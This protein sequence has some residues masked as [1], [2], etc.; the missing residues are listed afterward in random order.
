MLVIVLLV[1][2]ALVLGVFALFTILAA[3]RD[4]VERIKRFAVEQYWKFVKGVKWVAS[5]KLEYWPILLCGACLVI[6]A[7]TILCPTGILH[8]VWGN[9]G[10]LKLII[11]LM[12]DMVDIFINVIRQQHWLVKFLIKLIE[13]AVQLCMLVIVITVRIATDPNI[14]LIVLWAIALPAFASVVIWNIESSLSNRWRAMLM[15]DRDGGERPIE[16]MKNKL[17]IMC[18]ATIVAVMIA[19]T[20]V[21]KVPKFKSL[22]LGTTDVVILAVVVCIAQVFTT[23][24][25]CIQLDGDT[26]PGIS[27]G[28]RMIFWND[29]TVY[30]HYHFTLFVTCTSITMLLILAPFVNTALF[31]HRRLARI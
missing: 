12:S 14:P 20:I 4:D 1:C 5:Q 22:L 6:R 10:H 31:T 8:T 19:I 15:T 28:K 9:W 29:E 26:V 24:M 3:T 27:N 7:C 13:I 11:P 25:L 2:F 16:G 17:L 23:T 30:R 18:V 21:N